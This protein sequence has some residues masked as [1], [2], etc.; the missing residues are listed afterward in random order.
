MRVRSFGVIGLIAA[1]LI[2]SAKEASAT[3]EAIFGAGPTSSAMRG[4]GASHTASFEAAYENPALISLLRKRRVVLAGQGA[5][6]SLRATGGPGGERVPYPAYAAAVIGLELPIPFRQAL[7]DRVG[8][9][10]DLS[11]PTQVL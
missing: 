9:A 11:T 7:K 8:L 2:A 3:P 5:L 6:Y 4:T 10:L 1:A